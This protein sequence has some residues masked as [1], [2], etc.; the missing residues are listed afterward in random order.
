MSHSLHQHTKW[1]QLPS[2]NDIIF[3]STMRLIIVDLDV[4]LLKKQ[5]K[6]IGGHNAK[7]TC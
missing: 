5:Q 2:M 3:L 7:E 6:Q 4:S 1:V